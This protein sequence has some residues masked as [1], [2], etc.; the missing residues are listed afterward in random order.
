MRLA[1]VGGGGKFVD[2]DGD[3]VH[4][5]ERVENEGVRM[6]RLDE[7]ARE[8]VG[9]LEPLAGSPVR[10]AL[11]LEARHVDDVRLEGQGERVGLGDRRAPGLQVGRE[12]GREAELA[13]RAED[14]GGPE[15]E[16]GVG[17]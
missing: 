9:A 3:L 5:R 4:P 10:E 17:E 13:G 8:D 1:E 6:V 14:E 7:G 12:V 11:A 2:V 16:Q 15:G